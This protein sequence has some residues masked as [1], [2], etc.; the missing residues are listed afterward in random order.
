MIARCRVRVRGVRPEGITTYE[1]FIYFR[2]T[3]RERDLRLCNATT[4]VTFV[5]TNRR[6]MDYS[7]SRRAAARICEMES[8]T[9]TDGFESDECGRL[10]VWGPRL[11][12]YY[13]ITGRDMEREQI[14]CE[15]LQTILVLEAAVLSRKPIKRI[16]TRES[17]E[18]YSTCAKT[19]SEK[20]VF[21]CG[22][23]ETGNDKASDSSR[24]STAVR[25]EFPGRR[26]VGLFAGTRFVVTSFT[27]FYL[28]FFKMKRSVTRG[29]TKSRRA[30]TVFYQR[31][32][33]KNGPP[34]QGRD[35]FSVGRHLL[36]SSGW[37]A[38][39]KKKTKKNPVQLTTT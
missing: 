3:R 19:M 32:Y 28:F 30:R 33:I 8:S 17:C 9:S 36:A 2:E 23:A 25:K 35:E 24:H 6:E 29:E 38:G 14:S 26:S 27:F 10:C 7:M 34:P 18:L 4:G 31:A 11:I 13:L 5:L 1:I 22:R 37:V 16:E 15:M 21:A 12:T 20:L 39:R